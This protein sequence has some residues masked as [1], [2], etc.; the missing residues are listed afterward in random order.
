MT[1]RNKTVLVLAT[2]GFLISAMPWSLHADSSV[3][4]AGPTGGAGEEGLRPK[5]PPCPGCDADVLPGKCG[6]GFSAYGSLEAMQISYG[7]GVAPRP[8][9]SS[10]NQANRSIQKSMRSFQDSIRRMNDSINKIRNIGR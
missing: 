7:V 1:A 3:V 2:L 6:A 8:P 9:V 10:A 4:L 5:E